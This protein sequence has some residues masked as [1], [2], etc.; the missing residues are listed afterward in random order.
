M[1]ERAPTVNYRPFSLWFKGKAALSS[2]ASI[3]LK[4]PNSS[5]VPIPSPYQSLSRGWA[6]W[7]SLIVGH[8]FRGWEAWAIWWSSSVELHGWG[9]GCSLCVSVSV[10]VP[11]CVSPCVCAYVLEE[12]LPLV[13]HTFNL[14]VR[15]TG[16]WCTIGNPKSWNHAYHW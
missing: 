10:S 11:L 9:D 4:T 7:V 1:L 13:L 5:W 2:A 3:Y 6:T 16:T 12:L 14:S 8:G 15:H